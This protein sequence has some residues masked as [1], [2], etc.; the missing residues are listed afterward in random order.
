MDIR[1]S[2]EQEILKNLNEQLG[3]PPLKNWFNGSYAIYNE[4]SL[5]RTDDL[6]R[7]DRIMISGK[8]AIVVDYKTGE[9]KS[10]NYRWQVRRY[11]KILKETGIEKVEGFLWY[12]GLAEVEKVCEF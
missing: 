12:T 11:S 3:N 5:L 8:N 9:K 2:E 4:R 10:E 1:L 7:P 6:L